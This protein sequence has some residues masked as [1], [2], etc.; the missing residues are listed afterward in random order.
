MY[1][2]REKPKAPIVK[3]NENIVKIVHALAF[4]INY[5]DENN[6]KP[7]QYDLVKTLFLADRYHL[8]EWGRLITSDNYVAMKHGPVP[9]FAFDLLK[10]NVVALRKTKM[11]Q[12][13]WQQELYEDKNSKYFKY[14]NA[15]ALDFDLFLSDSD[16]EALI[17]NFIIVKTLGFSQIRK[18][19]HEDVAYIDAWEDEST[20]RQF[21]MSLGMLFDT[22]NYDKAEEIAEFS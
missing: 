18:L 6:P 9:S 4:V 17:N 20:R 13:P 12:L 3:L 10:G 21:P 1:G 2:I 14:F 11:S 22:P 7:S 19:T 15:R 16:K 8:N 5:A